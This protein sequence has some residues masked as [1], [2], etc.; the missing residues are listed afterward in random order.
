MLTNQDIIFFSD[1]WGRYPST[2]QHIAKILSKQNRILWIGSL[3]LRKPQ[4]S[5]KD[6]LRV[7]E[8]L[9]KIF[10]GKKKSLS[11]EK[12]FFINPL[13]I[14]FHDF[15]LLRKLNNYIITSVVKSKL[16][17]YNFQKPIL[18]T[19]S[20]VIAELIG[21]LNERASVYLC[22]DDYSLF[23]GAFKSLLYLENKIL[24]KVDIV[25]SVS[26]SL[27]K[28]RVP[29]SGKNYFL[30]QGV[31]FNHFSHSNNVEALNA[32]L[33]PSVI[34]FF[35]LISNWV[36]IDLIVECAKTYPKYS[37][38]II[39][40]SE[41]NIDE[42]IRLPN[43]EYLD[44]IPYKELP[45][46][47]KMFNVGLIPFKVNDLTIAVNPIKLIEYFALGI[48]V[49]ST[50]LPEVEKFKDL[51]LIARDKGEFVKL[52]PIAVGDNISERNLLRI[53]KAK[54]YAWDSIAEDVSQKIECLFRK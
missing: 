37:F 38:I 40:K 47:A 41:Q 9:K 13:I 11:Q 8:K 4:L 34:G 2:T 45:T 50:N 33:K 22:L 24:D 46:Y 49:L 5:F 6:I 36:D 16:K 42:M 48:P 7:V 43:V 53:S 12:V 35:G 44:E 18:F 28:S 3:G 52:L 17:K 14:P 23:K 54:N 20:P 32:S 26:D 31:D 1:D 27:L 15:A 29:K 21:K 51:V 10:F 30:P 25:F 39:G 19:S